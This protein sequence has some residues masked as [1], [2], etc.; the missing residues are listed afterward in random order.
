MKLKKAIPYYLTDNVPAFEDNV[1]KEE[2]THALKKSEKTP[3]D[4]KESFEEVLEIN[5]KHQPLFQI[6]RRL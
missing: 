6:I 3:V 4:A 2:K 5:T 1:T